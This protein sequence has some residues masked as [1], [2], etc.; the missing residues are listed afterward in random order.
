MKLRL[1]AKPK[2]EE[3]THS[4]TTKT[5]LSPGHPTM[6]SQPIT[7]LF[8]VQFNISTMP[9]TSTC[10]TFKNMMADILKVSEFRKKRKTNHSSNALAAYFKVFSR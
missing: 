5:H 9:L 1:K 2:L 3:K 4:N 7:S 6:V 10:L 8:Q